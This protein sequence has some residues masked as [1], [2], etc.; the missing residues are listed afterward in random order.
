VGEAELIARFKG[1]DRP[2]F[3]AIV[4]RH[5]AR[6]IGLARRFLGDEHDALDVAQDAFVALYKALPAWRPDAALFTWLYRTT[7]HLCARRL[8]QRGRV[9]PMTGRLPEKAA[10]PAVADPSDLAEALDR[11]LEQLTEKQRDVFLGCHEEGLTVD[12]VATRLGM[13]PGTARSH[14]HR[15]LAALRDA[16]RPDRAK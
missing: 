7:V 8:R 1:G 15:A 13:A 14:L 11:A 10:A 2:A 9:K 6:V 16:L 4:D 5:R 12:A 3:D